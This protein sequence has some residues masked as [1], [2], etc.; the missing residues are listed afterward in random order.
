MFRLDVELSIHFT[1]LMDERGRG[2]ALVRTFELPFAPTEGT[3]LTGAALNPYSASPE[4]FPLKGVTWD[5]DRNLFLA[6]IGLVCCDHPLAF[7][8]DE[9][10]AWVRC[11]WRFGRLEDDYAPP[12]KAARSGTG[13]PS[14]SGDSAGEDWEDEAELLPTLPARR[15]PKR[16]NKLMRALVRELAGAYNNS[17]IAYAI[18][19]T[20][21]YFTDEQLK[22]EDSRA[23]KAFAAACAEFAELSA[24]AR[25]AWE[26]R[27]ARTQPRL[28]RIVGFAGGHT[29]PEHST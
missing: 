27:V 18:D 2:I 14:D 6:H 26:D 7:I 19:R 16:F 13:A 22:H 20:H 10:R 24:D 4:G 5:I 3:C 28:D 17:D 23:K 21:F 29:A 15:R 9:L 1:P 12:E 11:G 25:N 8:P